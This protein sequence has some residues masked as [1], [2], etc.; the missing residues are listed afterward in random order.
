VSPTAHV[1]ALAAGAPGEASDGPRRSLVLAG[2]GMRV[3]Y[4]AGVMV[5]LEE[6]GLTFA[7]ADGTSG[8]TMNLAMLLSGLSP[9]EMCERWRTLRLTGFMSPL[10][11]RDYLKGP[12][13]PALGGS[14]GI[15]RRV[16]PHLGVDVER[17]RAAEGIDG[18]FNVCNFTRKVNEAIHHRDVD[19]DLLV[20]G[21]SLPIFSPAVE[22]GGDTY[23]DSVW[24]KDANVLE[25]AERD[26]DDLWLVWCI[27]NSGVYRNG[28][29]LQYVHMIELSANGSL[30]EDLGRI[31]ER[32]AGRK[33][34]VRV[35]VIKPEWPLPLD[36]DFFFGRI[37]AATLIALGYRDA[38]RYLDS[39]SPDGVALDHSAARMRDPRPGIAWRLALGN[40][41][42]SVRACAEVEDLDALERGERAL[43]VGDVSHPAIGENVL[44]R[45]GHVELSRDGRVRWELRL[46]EHCL[47]L[48][49]RLAGSGLARLRSATSAGA[50]LHDGPTPDAPVVA[51]AELRGRMLP[52]L[53]SVHAR[54]VG[55][56]AEGARA[57]GR[58][59]RLA[60]GRGAR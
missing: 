45:D 44:A 32:N 17:I 36:P 19:M 49:Q 53:L 33:R 37:D 60:A 5:A 10:P 4:Q 2:G 42:L 6:E 24:I 20:A 8:G 13:F 43:A 16:Y 9:R 55:S 34:P 59:A 22:H 31:A 21:V 29:F 48:E 35:H 25:A 46:R 27:G 40:G 28:A 7:H 54:G 38:C 47:V 23:L 1:P 11:L 26:C 51:S 56:A 50:T 3:A 57:V 52:L 41:E 18:T 14:G 12:P 15:R 39:M 58:F 30:A